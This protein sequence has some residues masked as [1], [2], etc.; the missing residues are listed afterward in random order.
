MVGEEHMKRTTTTS[1]TLEQHIALGSDIK[2]FK[3]RMNDLLRN[4]AGINT[5]APLSKWAWRTLRSLEELQNVLD[6]QVYLE[7][8]MGKHPQLFCGE[9]GQIY[10]GPEGHAAASLQAGI[11]YMA[12][13][14]QTAPAQTKGGTQ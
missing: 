9:Y 6:A 12:K 3:Q 2:K 8:G 11:D 10:Y 5:T 13:K 14:A 7:V 4:M 1:L